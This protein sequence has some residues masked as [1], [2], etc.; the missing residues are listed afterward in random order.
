ML[1][2]LAAVVVAPLAAEA[3][4]TH[5]VPRIV[6]LSLVAPAEHTR[7]FEHGLRALGY[8]PGTTIAIGYRSADGRAPALPALAKEAVA[9]QPQ[10][11]VAIG[12]SAAIAARDATRNIP[13]VAVSGD[14]T[15]AGLVTNLGRPDGNVTG[16][17]FFAVD[18]MLKRFELLMEIAPN[19]RRVTVLVESPPHPTQRKGLV[20]LRAAATHT[21]PTSWRS[22]SVPPPTSIGFFAVPKPPICPSSSPRSSNSSSTSRPRRRSAS[23]SRRRSCCARIR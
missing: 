19:M 15:A 21:R 14:I 22:G 23:R 3:Q 10:A 8:E 2:S 12:T 7:A 5:S 6:L 1:T 13:I 20:T 16:L 4:E 11:I 9:L 18:L 17:S